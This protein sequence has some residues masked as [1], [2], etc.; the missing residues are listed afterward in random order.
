MEEIIVTNGAAI[1]SNT[2]KFFDYSYKYK[3]LLSVL[4][5]HQQ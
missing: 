4:V 3:L 2:A 5:C 1:G